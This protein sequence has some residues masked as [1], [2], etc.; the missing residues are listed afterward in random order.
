MGAI[1]LR[2]SFSNLQVTLVLLEL[3]ALD[4]LKFSQVLYLHLKQA[5]SI[6]DCLE[7]PFL[8]RVHGI[9]F[10]RCLCQLD[11][12]LLWLLELIGDKVACLE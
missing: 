9:P 8:L 1:D 12:R 5:S 11:D 4:Y 7:D 6:L 2:Y 3:I 10:E